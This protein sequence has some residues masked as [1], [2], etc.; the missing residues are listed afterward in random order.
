MRR[1]ALITGASAGIGEA[2][3]RAYAARG[4]DVALTAR[5]ADRLTALATTL[6]E[7]HGVEAIPIPADLAD[8]S[9]PERIVAALNGRTV[10][11]LVNNAGYGLR[12]GFADQDGPAQEAFIQV[13]I[14]AVPALTRL[15]L[16]GMR[17]R[18]YGRII[19]VA[20]VMGLITALPGSSMYSG[21]KAFVVSFSEGLHL[22]LEGSGVHVTALCP[23]LTHSEFHDVAPFPRMSRAPA[24]LWMSAEAVVAAGLD[25]V[26]ANRAV[27]TTG[28][29]NRALVA[30]SRVLPRAWA[31]ALTARA[32]R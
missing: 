32:G 30:L 26:E 16:P 10:D 22:E 20:S 11:A 13:L 12:G 28:A 9:A 24:W 15:V 4:W 25:A 21:A 27:C 7:R 8:P 31:L 23:G 1:L 14:A 6:A 19:N 3:A 29:A 5:R 17:Q 2:F 18:G